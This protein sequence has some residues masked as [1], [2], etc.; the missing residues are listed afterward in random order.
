MATCVAS[1]SNNP[2]GAGGRR[3]S[4]V[5]R[6][7]TKGGLFKGRSLLGSL[8]YFPDVFFII[9][10][11]VEK[12]AGNNFRLLLIVIF[13]KSLVTVVVNDVG[14]FLEYFFQERFECVTPSAIFVL[15]HVGELVQEKRLVFFLL[16][17]IGLPW[18]GNEVAQGNS[19]IDPSEWS[20]LMDANHFVVQLISEH[21]FCQGFLLVVQR[22]ITD[23]HGCESE[24]TYDDERTNGGN[25]DFEGFSH[26]VRIAKVSWFG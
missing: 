25:D 24:R 18:E 22:A 23:K 17:V 6:S 9:L 15:P 7:W 4:G 21:T 8:L 19:R 5:R 16:G 13:C 1:V 11:P 14:V 2:V 12:E 20:T 10:R 26:D 3:E